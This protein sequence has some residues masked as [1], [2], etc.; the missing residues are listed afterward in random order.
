MREN[1]QKL[2]C[3]RSDKFSW[4]AEIAHLLQLLKETENLLIAAKMQKFCIF[5]VVTIDQKFTAFIQDAEILHAVKP[6][7]NC[8]PSIT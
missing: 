5:L 8:W 7:E 2:Y 6:E 3:I 1:L 4:N